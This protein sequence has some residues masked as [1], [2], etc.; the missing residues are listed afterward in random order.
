MGG[1]ALLDRGRYDQRARSSGVAKELGLKNAVEGQKDS[2][3]LRGHI[4]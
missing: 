2:L 1:F 4:R 3:F